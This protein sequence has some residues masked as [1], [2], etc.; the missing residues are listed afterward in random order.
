MYSCCHPPH[1]V[2]N[3]SYQSFWQ[4]YVAS[5]NLALLFKNLVTGTLCIFYT[6]FSL[7]GVQIFLNTTRQ[8]IQSYCFQQHHTFTWF[9]IYRAVLPGT[10]SQSKE[11]TRARYRTQASVSNV[12]CAVEGSGLWVYLVQRETGKP[13]V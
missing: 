7:Y 8:R 2:N 10:R 11:R 3:E 6:E 4:P 9:Q 13:K 12:R 1:Q 5:N